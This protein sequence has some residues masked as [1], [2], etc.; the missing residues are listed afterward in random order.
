MISLYKN[1]VSRFVISGA[2]F[3]LF[4]F[5][6]EIVVLTMFVMMMKRYSNHQKLK[7]VNFRIVLDNHFLYIPLTIYGYVKSLHL[8][9][10]I[11]LLIVFIISLQFHPCD[12]IYRHE[13]TAKS[14]IYTKI[15]NKKRK[16]D[17]ETLN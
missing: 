3:L 9:V 8:F 1:D 11:K 5:L 12:I 4:F 2:K 16:I 13:Y 14:Q 17:K 10:S 7:E 6:A 15:L